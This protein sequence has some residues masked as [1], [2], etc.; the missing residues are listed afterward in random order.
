MYEG[1]TLSYSQLSGASSYLDWVVPALLRHPDAQPLLETMGLSA[2]Q[3]KT[4]SGFELSLI[5]SGEKELDELLEQ[6]SQAVQLEELLH[7]DLQV[8]Y[9]EETRAYLAQVAQVVYPYEKDNE[10]IGKLSVSELKKMSRIPEETEGEELYQA[11]EVVPL[12]P[13]FRETGEAL[14]G[15]ARGTAYHAFL[16]NLDYS[17]TDE[18]EIQL[19]ELISC[20]KMNREEKEAIYLDDIRAFLARPIG[21]RIRRAALAGVLFREQP[22]VLGVPAD[23]IREGW[24]PQETVLV[25]GIIDAYFL[26]G[27]E[28]VILDYKTDKVSHPQILADKYRAQLD[29]Y[30]MALQRLTGCKVK[31]RMIYSFYFG[32]EIIL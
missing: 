14:T 9:D 10:I 4:T 18:L 28:L 11:E 32:E 30:S 20:G 13:A 15:A 19:E 23:Q 6:S 8:C 26:E 2:K 31:E 22:F 7:L 17:R 25:Q 24:N 1:E 12:I 16:E 21:G 29:Y 3:Q 27:D 5:A